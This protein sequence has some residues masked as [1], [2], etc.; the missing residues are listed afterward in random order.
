MK[1]IILS[2]MSVFAL[3]GFFSSCDH[4]DASPAR[5]PDA[6]AVN[7][8]I[9]LYYPD[10]VSFDSA[11]VVF[12][13]STTEIELK[14]NLD[15]A[16]HIATG[17]ITDLPCGEWKVSTSYFSTI[18]HGTLE[19]NGLVKL[20]ITS[21]STDLIS[22]E[23][24]V[25]IEEKAD[26]IKLRSFKW[27]DYCHH[28]IFI[29]NKREGFVRLPRDPTNPFTE[30]TTFNP[31]WTYV[32]AYRSFYHRNSEPTSNYYQGGGAF[33]IYGK[34][35]DNYDLLEN[36]IVD[37]TSLESGISMVRDKVWNFV[38]GIILMYDNNGNEFLLFH[39]WD[40]RIPGGRIKSVSP[41]ANRSRSEIDNRKS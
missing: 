8:N 39:T 16:S 36:H 37:T 13:N 20:Q 26:P 17:Y 30:I 14:L 33:E 11:N 3:L 18:D 12:K 23:T 24:F 6:T 21:T 19:K 4:E 1:K 32:F 22:T 38:D 9:H 28:Q 10:L 25:Y 34:G 5:D 40:L 41:P 7:L 27:T 15:N 2:A 31:R 29:E 35:G